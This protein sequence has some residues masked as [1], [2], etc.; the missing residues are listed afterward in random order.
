MNGVKDMNRIDRASGP[1]VFRP[2]L[3]VL[4]LLAALLL[5][6]AA[7]AGEGANPDWEERLA[8]A[9]CRSRTRLRWK[10]FWSRS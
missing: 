8:L 2:V 6:A 7:A 9:R 4:C 3:R 5:V 10:P 1:S